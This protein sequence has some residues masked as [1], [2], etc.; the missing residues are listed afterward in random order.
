MKRYWFVATRKDNGEVQFEAPMK[1]RRC[2]GYTSDGQRCKRR[3]CLSFPFCWQHTKSYSKLA[4][5]TSKALKQAGIDGQMGL[6]AHCPGRKKPVFR[7][8]HNIVRYLGEVMHDSDLNKR[9]QYKGAP[10][11]VVMSPY[12]MELDDE[13][14]VD[15]ALLRGVAAYA[16]S[17]AGTGLK[18]NAQLEV[19]DLQW[20][21]TA[22]LVA[23]KNIYHGDE[24]LTDYGKHYF[25]YSALETKLVKRCV[26]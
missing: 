2:L 8:G 6:Y 26:Q 13:W 23:K 20:P 5:K 16:N 25:K 24:I 12:A 14:S 17:P 10:H 3:I 21:P 15:A 9:Y 1:R 4:V 18:P 19:D 11:G 7:R 22:W